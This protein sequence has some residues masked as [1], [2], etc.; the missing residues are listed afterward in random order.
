LLRQTAEQARDF[1][2]AREL[3]AST[4]ICAPAIFILSGARAG[5][6]CVI[7]RLEE[8]AVIHDGDGAV[9]NHWLTPSLGP[10]DRGIES[11]RRCLEMQALLRGGGAGGAWLRYPVVN[12]LTRLA[13][14]ANAAAGRLMVQ[15]YERDGPATAPLFLEVT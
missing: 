9:A 7:E 10:G 15:G 11:G 4:P 2:A 13:V 12:K 5:E 14:E 8:R 6:G 1:M 3:L